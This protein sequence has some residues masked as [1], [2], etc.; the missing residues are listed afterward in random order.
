VRSSNAFVV[1]ATLVSAGLPTKLSIMVQYLCIPV[2]AADAPAAIT[3][4]MSG[5]EL[6]IGSAG[7]MS[8][9]PALS[10]RP[11]R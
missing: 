3:E 11:S 10:R 1:L 2:D 9:R 7:A 5:E 4:L 6:S 8:E